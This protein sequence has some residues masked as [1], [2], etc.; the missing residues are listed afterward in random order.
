MIPRIVLLSIVSILAVSPV[1]AGTKDDIRELQAKM[2]QAEQALAANSAMTVRIGEL[3]SQIQK[4]TGDIETLTYQLD[5]ANTRLDAVSAVLAGG[6]VTDVD[7]NF[8]TTGEAGPIDLATGDPIADQLSNGADAMPPTTNSGDATG[9][10]GGGDI[11]LPLDPNA[12]FDY[13]SSYLLKGDY[14]NAKSAFALYVEAFPNHT[15]TADAQ[16]RLGEIHLALGENAA[17]ADVFINHIRN[18]PNDPRSAEAYLKLGSAFSRLEKTSEAC[19]VFKTLK[20]KF[21]NAPTPV[22]QRADIE[23]A[24]ISCS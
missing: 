4:L 9:A 20:T 6:A 17:A 1:K 12:A 15:R 5:Q 14:A 19:T 8:A 10:V 21:P 2:A 18:Y 24:R 11:S 13:A 7:G 16:F 23:M 22:S 3:E